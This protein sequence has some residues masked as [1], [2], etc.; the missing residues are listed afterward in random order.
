VKFYI[1]VDADEVDD[2]VRYALETAYNDTKDLK[3]KEDRKI[4]K[5]LRKAHNF[6]APPELHIRK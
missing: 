1:K 6:F 4:R 3:H 2:I 5:A